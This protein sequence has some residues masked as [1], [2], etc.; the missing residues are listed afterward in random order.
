[1][2]HAK[3]SVADSMFD[4]EEERM[5]QEAM[6]QSMQSAIEEGHIVPDEKDDGIEP[7]GMAEVSEE[8]K[9]N[10]PNVGN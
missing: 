3:L 7:V 5:I 8:S 1:M 10:D 4:M 9:A 2:D 6:K